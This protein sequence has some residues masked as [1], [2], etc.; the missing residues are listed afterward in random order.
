MRYDTKVNIKKRWDGKRYFGSRIYPPIP[1]NNNDIYIVTNE[2]DSLDNLS[3][4]Y[5]KNPTLWWIIAQAN[6]IGKG[7]MAVPG[8]LQLR[9]PLNITSIINN[10]DSLNSQ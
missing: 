7:K 10:F 6:N 8:G 5:Y 3:F 2:T 1:F 9:I 4:K